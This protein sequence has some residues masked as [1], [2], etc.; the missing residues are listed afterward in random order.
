MSIALPPKFVKVPD[1][2]VKDNWTWSAPVP[3]DVPLVEV[4][5][6]RLPLIISAPEF[7]L[8]IP[9]NVALPA[10]GVTLRTLDFKPPIKSNSLA[11][12]SSFVVD[13]ENAKVELV[14]LPSAI[15]IIEVGSLFIKSTAF[16][17]HAG[18]H[19]LIRLILIVL[20]IASFLKS[21]TARFP[22]VEL[23]PE[24][25]KSRAWILNVTAVG[26]VCALNRI[27]AI[28]ST[29]IVGQSNV[30]VLTIVVGE[31]TSAAAIASC[32]SLHEVT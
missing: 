3:K 19:I 6:P 28:F 27:V 16:W 25:F 26:V 24:P 1:V 22:P 15:E 31:P 18:G 5:V 29:Y 10:V 20:V 30:T 13:S 21:Q 17:R 32:N 4:N 7:N 12:T 8:M 11:M 14:E 9:L 2:A 23:V